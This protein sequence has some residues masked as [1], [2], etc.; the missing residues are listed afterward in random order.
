MITLVKF[1][2]NYRDNSNKLIS[3]TLGKL[4]VIKREYLKEIK[5]KHN[6]WWYVSIEEE[7][8]K[9]TEGGVFVFRPI[10]VLERNERGKQEILHLFPGAY[11]EEQQDTSVFLHPYRVGFPWVCPITLKRYIIN[12]HKENDSYGITSVVVVHSV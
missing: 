6:E 9:G 2:N 5:P 10:K 11:S 7:V 8:G 12:K 4:G 1:I 3:R